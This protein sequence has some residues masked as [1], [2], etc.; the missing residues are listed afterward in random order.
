[1]VKTSRNASATNLQSTPIGTF[2]RGET[3]GKRKAVAEKVWVRKS[4]HR[5]CI[6]DAH[7]PIDEQTALAHS[8]MPMSAST[9]METGSMTTEHASTDEAIQWF[10]ID[11]LRRTDAE[12][13]GPR[14]ALIVLNQPITPY[15]GIIRG[16]WKN[17]TPL[18][19]FV[20]GALY[21]TCPQPSPTSQPMAA[22]TACTKPPASTAT[23]SL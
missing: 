1:L 5:S 19:I 14:F 10:P 13:R 18:S 17:G 11:L 7:S 3:R 23:P 20:A 15:L 9:G 4:P 2:C 22:P 21:L 6:S 16:L 12:A 8:P